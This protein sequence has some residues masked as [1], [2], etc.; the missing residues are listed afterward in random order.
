MTNEERMKLQEL[1]DW[2]EAVRCEEEAEAAYKSGDTRAARRLANRS[3]RLKTLARKK[4]K[5][6]AT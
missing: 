3:I 6:Q 4:L 5:A 2:Q 1:P